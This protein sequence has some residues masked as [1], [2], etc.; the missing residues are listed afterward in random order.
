MVTV[1][2]YIILS[3]VMVL[4][5]WLEKTNDDQLS[6]MLTNPLDHPQT[7]AVLIVAVLGSMVNTLGQLANQDVSKAITGP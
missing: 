2:R 1:I 6:A 7:W 4:A 3:I 5:P